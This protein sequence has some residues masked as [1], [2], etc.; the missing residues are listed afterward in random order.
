MLAVYKK[1]LRAYFNSIIGWPFLAFFL[2]FIGIYFFVNN[3]FYGYTHFGYAL[4]SVILIFIL[5]VPMVTMRIMAEENKQK[6]DQLLFTSP[7]SVEKIIL[8]KYFAVVTLFAIVVLVT[9]TYPLIMAA[10]GEVNFGMNYAAIFGFFLLGCAYLAIG[11]FISALTESQAFAAIVTFIVVLFTYLMDGIASLFSTSARTAW[12]V[13]AFLLLLVAVLTWLLMKSKLVTG[14]FLV[15][16]QGAL[17]AVYFM[18]PTIFDGAV[19]E[20]FGWFSVVARFDDFVSG[21][22]NVSS[23]VYYLSIV[24]LFIFLTVQAIKKRRWN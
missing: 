6:T 9:C 12:L 5:L 3:L 23:V 17:A 8:G 14:M 24:V 18:K 21:I 11:T 2:A 20:V 7:V 13:F 19:V 22:F 10:F 4:Y 1:E 15:I 16:S